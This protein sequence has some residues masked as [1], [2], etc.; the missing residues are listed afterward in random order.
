MS[1]IC[2]YRYF[3]LDVLN[4]NRGIFNIP[5]KQVVQFDIRYLRVQNS[6]PN[7]TVR[8]SKCT[9]KQI[10]DAEYCFFVSIQVFQLITVRNV[11]FP[12]KRGFTVNDLKLILLRCSEKN[13]KLIYFT[14]K[15]LQNFHFEL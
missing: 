4:T 7:L 3:I 11:K 13:V 10:T 14:R 2:F 9:V 6:V 8:I 15:Q 12:D 1:E 5:T